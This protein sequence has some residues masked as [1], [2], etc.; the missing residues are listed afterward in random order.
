MTTST[1]GSDSYSISLN[2]LLLSLPS[3]S[4]IYFLKTITVKAAWDKDNIH[5]FRDNQSWI[6]DKWHKQSTQLKRVF[7]E[8][9]FKISL[10]KQANA[11]QD[12]LII[13]R[14]GKKK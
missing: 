4:N 12:C 10:N 3:L 8:K 11:T 1:D 7:I 2:T 6:F 14:L 5:G 9:G 13:R